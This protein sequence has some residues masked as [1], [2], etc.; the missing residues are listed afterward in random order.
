[1][2]ANSH[3]HTLTFI[4][5]YTEGG[6]VNAMTLWPPDTLSFNRSLTYRLALTHVKPATRIQNQFLTH[7]FPKSFLT[8]LLFQE[9]FSYFSW[10]FTRII[11]WKFGEN[12][13][14]TL[15]VCRKQTQRKSLFWVKYKRTGIKNSYT[16]FRF[17]LLFTFL[18]GFSLSL[19][20]LSRL[21]IF[22]EFSLL[23]FFCFNFFPDYFNYFIDFLCCYFLLY[24]INFC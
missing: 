11:P 13:V 5:L 10:K 15:F 19:F 20:V 6:E 23:L 24:P 18:C 14:N 22:Q 3:I 2:K 16:F 9:M 4:L 1:M 8:I 17:F 21:I 7:F 12:S